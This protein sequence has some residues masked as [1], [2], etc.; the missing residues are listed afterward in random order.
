MISYGPSEVA[1]YP[2]AVLSSS[3]QIPIRISNDTHNQ[4]KT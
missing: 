2:Y 4:F 1:K 3:S